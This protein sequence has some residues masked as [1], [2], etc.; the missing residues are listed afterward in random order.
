V[1]STQR[2]IQTEFS[3]NATGIT[4]SQYGGMNYITTSFTARATK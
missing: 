2:L 3:E 1:N 4:G